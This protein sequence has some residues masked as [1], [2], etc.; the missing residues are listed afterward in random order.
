MKKIKWILLILA[1]ITFVPVLDS[2]T[3]PPS[4]IDYYTCP[5][6]PQIHKDAP[7]QCP[8]CGMDLVPVKKVNPN[9]NP[10]TQKSDGKIATSQGIEI[11][12]NYAQNIGVKIATAKIRPLSKYL[13]TYAKIAHDPK[14]WLAQNEYIQALR[15]GDAGLI[16]SS[17]LKLRFMGLSEEW[18]ARL[19]KNRQADLGFHLAENKDLTL[20]EAFVYQKEM[21]LIKMGQVVQILDQGNNQLGTGKV[22]AI[23]NLLDEQTRALKI[24]VR[25]D[26][27]LHLRSNT[28]VQIKIAIP[29]GDKLSVPRDAVIFYGDHNMV[30]VRHG[31]THYVPMKVELGQEAGE[32]Y[33]IISGLQ[34][35][36][37]V[38][39]NGT[40]LIDSESK[41]KMPGGGHQ[42]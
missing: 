13:L 16:K 4:D 38:V 8:I 37:T 42:H 28:S 18:I 24:I 1:I 5:M 9:A 35:G 34:D 2:C 41:L 21:E 29:L 15:L 7:G 36:D 23:A 17:E 20:I 12:P 32:Y 26:T 14:L 40:F 19:K 10:E 6:H 22:E 27:V 31:E 11:D 25:S 3:K 30:Y 39:T 33:E